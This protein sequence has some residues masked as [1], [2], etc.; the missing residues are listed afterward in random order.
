MAVHDRHGQGDGPGSVVA[1]R[2][3]PRSIR[4]LGQKPR[5]TSRT[6]FATYGDWPLAIAAYNRGPGTVNK[7]LAPCRR[8]LQNLDFW[9]IYYYLPEETRGYLPMFIAANYVMNY[10]PHHNI[11]PVLPTKPLVTDTRS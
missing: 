10:Y 8:R 7:A 6:S 1:C 2:R 5:N 4:L 9:A 3:A 11:S